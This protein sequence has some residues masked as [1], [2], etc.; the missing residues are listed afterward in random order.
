MAAEFA[1]GNRRV[2]STALAEGIATGSNAAKKTVLF[3]NRRGSARFV[4]CR[5][6][7]HVPEVSAL[8]DGAG[9][10]IAARR[11]LRCHMV[12][13][14]RPC[15]RRLGTKCGD[16]PV[17][18]FGAGTERVAAEAAR[19]FPSAVIVR[20]D[21]DTTTRIGDHARLLDRFAGAGDILVGTQM[22]AK[23]LDFPTVTL[24]GAV[25]ADLDLHVAD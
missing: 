3:I 19:L 15:S 5:T 23:G 24:V 9:R 13:L 1:A 8:F 11:L 10:C 14:S 18:E 2:F 6:C 4:L 7:G 12:R 22:V 25:A 21:S 16:G 20:M 17:R